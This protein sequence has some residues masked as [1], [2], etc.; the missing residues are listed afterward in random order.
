MQSFRS[1]NFRGVVAARDIR[2][3]FF[4][5]EI[6]LSRAVQD[7][8]LK[9]VQRNLRDFEIS[10]YSRPMSPQKRL[11]LGRRYAEADVIVRGYGEDCGRSRRAS[12]KTSK[13]HGKTGR[14]EAAGKRINLSRRI[15]VLVH[16]AFGLYVPDARDTT[17]TKNG[18]KWR[19]NEIWCPIASK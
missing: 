8:S 6:F 9:V 15:S 16:D 18:I 4:D 2:V 10:W 5:S 13:G 11:V 3:I 17:E 1:T 7:R 14:T 12:L 19:P